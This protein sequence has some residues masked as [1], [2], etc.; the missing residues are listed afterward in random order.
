MSDFTSHL[1]LMAIVVTITVQNISVL[2][3]VVGYIYKSQNVNAKREKKETE[4][5]KSNIDQPY[6]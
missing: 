5:P 6:F 3:F 2:H 1:V 4:S